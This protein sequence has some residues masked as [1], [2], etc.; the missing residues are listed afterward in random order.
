MRRLRSLAASGTPSAAGFALKRR[1]PPRAVTQAHR[2]LREGIPVARSQRPMPG[3]S[4]NAPDVI[5]LEL[6]GCSDLTTAVVKTAADL[7]VQEAFFSEIAEMLGIGHLCALSVYREGGVSY[8]EIVP[9]RT[10]KD[11]GVV[12]VED[13]E[14]VLRKSYALRF[15]Q[16]PAEERALR[17]RVDREL[18]QYADWLVAQADRS[19]NNGIAVPEQGLL[20]WIDEG[21]LGTGERLNPLYP[22]M[23]HDSFMANTSKRLGRVKLCPQT[24][25]VIAA[26]CTP[27]RL[28]EAHRHLAKPAPGISRPQGALLAL[29]R[30]DWYLNRML[31]R[32]EAV[33]RTGELTYAAGGIRT[34]GL[35]VSAA[36]LRAVRRE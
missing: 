23:P 4:S 2:A 35:H 3:I 32:R 27:E 26:R 31:K 28:R 10:L 20:R 9:G 19:E 24:L 11:A 6:A 12:S 17:A 8:M 7:G 34:L 33:L 18:L 30:S 15:P 1:D 16:M 25:E 21:R 36:L 14:R 29:L 22:W 5:D 13:L